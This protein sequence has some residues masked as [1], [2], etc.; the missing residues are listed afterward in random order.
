MPRKRKHVLQQ[1]ALPSTIKPCFSC[2]TPQTSTPKCRTPGRGLR[3]LRAAAS[4]GETHGQDDNGDVGTTDWHVPHLTPTQGN[5]PCVQRHANGVDHTAQPFSH[6]RIST[7][8]RH[9][10]CICCDAVPPAR[11]QQLNKP[12]AH[13]VA[14]R[15][16]QAQHELPF[17]DTRATPVTLCR[18]HTDFTHVVNHLRT[19]NVG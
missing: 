5:P 8:C 2:P 15:H 14:P 6:A 4:H 19:E 12:P 10:M 3:A 7:T 1:R 11:T 9:P 13:P 16:T 18:C 17:L